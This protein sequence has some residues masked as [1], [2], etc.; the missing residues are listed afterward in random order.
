MKGV[1]ED[2]MAAMRSTKRGCTGVEPET[3]NF[4]GSSGAAFA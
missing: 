4:R 2:W 1:I 3:A